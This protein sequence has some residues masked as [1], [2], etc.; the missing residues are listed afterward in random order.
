M[1]CL[2]VDIG[3]SSIKIAEIDS[4][5]RSATLNQV[6]ELN[7]SADPTRDQT[8][9]VIE[10]LRGF[11]SQYMMSAAK[12]GDIRWIIGVP[13]KSVASRLR[14]LPFTDRQKILKVLSFELEEEIPFDPSETVF[15]ARIVE[16][17]PNG[18]DVVVVAC[19][20]APIERALQQAKDG[21]FEPSLITS[22]GMALANVLDT[23][24]M[25]PATN[26]S[27]AVIGDEFVRAHDVHEAYALV[28]IG[29]TQTNVIVFRDKHV[30]AIRSIPWGGHD[31]AL[32]IESVFK[33][34][35]IEAMKVLQTKSFVLLNTNGVSR[36]QLAMHKAVSE[37]AAPLLREVRTTILDVRTSAGSEIRSLRLTGGASQIQN[38]GPW[39][40]QS[41]DVATNQL[42]YFNHLNA[43]A[44]IQVRVAQSPEIENVAASAIGLA[45]EGLRKSVNPAINLR[46]G[47]F[48]KSN[49]S[50]RVFLENWG[51][52]LQL[53][54][55]IFLVFLV[56][57]VLRD[58][59]TLTLAEQSDDIV[60]TA[61]KTQAGLKNA[62]ANASGISR[63]IQ[64]ELRSIKNRETLAQ[65]DEYIS[66]L[67]FVIKMAE[68]FPVQIPV[69]DGRGFDID[70]V[71]LDNDELIIEGRAQG[72]DLLAAIERELR[73]MARKGSVKSSQPTNLRSGAPGQPF[74]FTMKL[75]R[76]P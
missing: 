10:K 72:A 32:T 24:W 45:I 62:Q 15:D 70:H 59:T 33:V 23:W 30:V 36:D 76:K 66:A 16:V 57:S 48:A 74:G 54:V 46:R 3:S 40:T 22:E 47:I 58:G 61:A 9:E 4:S 42:E 41:L 1:K 5:G 8:V 11:S 13:Q 12:P 14:R 53:A 19:P 75:D 56:Y 55:A 17:F 20:H 50:V 27:Q 51:T 49:D 35:Y 7:L 68:K 71:S 67:D 26:P 18:V 43:S 2:G 69:K 44:K 64:T 39:L 28:Q 65:M 63:Y 34:P 25:P 52:T 29:H 31:V 38:F 73:S 21:G 37:A 60:T 6:W